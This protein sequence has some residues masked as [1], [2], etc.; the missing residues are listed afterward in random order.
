LSP[1]RLLVVLC[2]RGTTNLTRFRRP[3]L[4]SLGRGVF[5]R[6]ASYERP[7]S[8]ESRA[9]TGIIGDAI[10]ADRSCTLPDANS[11]SQRDI[12]RVM[13]GMLIT[14]IADKLHRSSLSFED[15]LA[16]LLYQ[17]DWSIPARHTF[18]PHPWKCCECIRN[19]SL[20]KGRRDLS[21][22][23]ISQPS[24]GSIWA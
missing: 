7:P 8:T 22:N 12:S 13:E 16:L 19:A 15:R 6:S 23:R 14:S 3:S 24:L 20:S 17:S 2:G 11:I 18:Q 5:L 10:P 1:S 21:Y 4:S 9:V